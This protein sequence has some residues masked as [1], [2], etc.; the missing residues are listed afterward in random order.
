MN[1]SSDCLE[2]WSFGKALYEALTRDASGSL[3]F[4][5]AILFGTAWIACHT[6]VQTPFIDAGLAGGAVRIVS[7]SYCCSITIQKG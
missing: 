4:H 6:R 5:F 2:G 1:E 7:A 3:V